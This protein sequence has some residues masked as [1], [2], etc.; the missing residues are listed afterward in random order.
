MPDNAFAKTRDLIPGNRIECGDCGY[1]DVCLEH[2]SPVIVCSC[3][4]CGE[5]V[6]ILHDGGDIIV[7]GVDTEEANCHCVCD[8]ALPDEESG[9]ISDDVYCSYCHAK[10]FENDD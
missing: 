7:E 3:S 9:D 6:A 10:L 1:R 2:N 8:D 4:K 5:S